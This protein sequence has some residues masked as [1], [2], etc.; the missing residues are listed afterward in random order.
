MHSQIYSFSLAYCGSECQGLKENRLNFDIHFI[1]SLKPC[2]LRI[3]FVRK[4]GKNLENLE[5]VWTMHFSK[6]LHFAWERTSARLV[7]A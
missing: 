6:L 1:K 3:L 5:R 2:D 7:R 4:K